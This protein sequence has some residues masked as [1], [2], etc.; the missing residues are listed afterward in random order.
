MDES[1]QPRD[2]VRGYGA[3]MGVCLLN[4]L[5]PGLGLIRL[6]RYRAGFI[7]LALWLALF[8][9]ILIY[10]AAGPQLTYGSYLA[11]V[12]FVLL[13][14][15]ALYA[16]AIVL[17]WRWSGRH[18]ARTGR[19]W[20][21]YGVL[22]IFAVQMVMLE[23]PV[24]Y[25]RTYYR[26]FYAASAAMA[27]TLAPDDRVVAAMRG[28]EPLER[29]DIVI[30]LRN[31][32]EYVTRIAGLPGDTI[33]MEEGV[34]VL[35]GRPAPQRA[36][37][38][39][40]PGRAAILLERF[41]GESAPHEILDDGQTISDTWPEVTLGEGEYFMLGDNRDHAADSRYPTETFGLGLVPREAIRGRVLFG[42][43]RTG[44]GLGEKPL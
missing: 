10:Y 34:A 7:L 32:M 38:R 21:W 23:L 27:P 16:T 4:L 11:V 5:G 9:V 26:S 19:L 24:R 13:A 37:E 33:A 36:A 44:E 15:L 14:T 12:G 6:G 2:L 41:P 1:E 25:A 22:G 29:G 17:S 40:E 31:G 20:R 8:C 28:F 43:W 30:V 3:R 42:Y 18:D 39:A 35:N